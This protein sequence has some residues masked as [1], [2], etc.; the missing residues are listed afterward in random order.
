ML[1]HKVAVFVFFF[2]SEPFA[3]VTTLRSSIPGYKLDTLSIKVQRHNKI[4]FHIN[5]KGQ[6]LCAQTVTAQ[7]LPERRN[8]SQVKS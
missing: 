8:A 6:F 3:E 4:A 5:H 7:Q 2:L 1:E